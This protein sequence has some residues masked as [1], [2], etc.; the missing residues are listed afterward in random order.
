[1]EPLVGDVATIAG[2]LVDYWAAGIDVFHLRGFE[3][4][5]DVALHAAVM[6]EVLARTTPVTLK[7]VR[8]DVA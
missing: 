8:A 2:R 5:P 3:P 7:E 4:L 1:M 6:T